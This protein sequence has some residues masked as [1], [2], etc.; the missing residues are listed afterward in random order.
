MARGRVGAADGER[1]DALAEL[2]AWRLA[3]LP[4]ADRRAVESIA[5]EDL[6]DF[7]AVLQAARYLM[8]KYDDRREVRALMKDLVGI[9]E[10]STDGLGAIDDQICELVLSVEDSIRR[11]KDAQARMGVMLPAGGH[12]DS[13]TP[14]PAPASALEP[15]PAPAPAPASALEPAPAPAPVLTAAQ[16][17]GGGGGYPRPRA[18]VAAGGPGRPGA[19]RSGVNNLTSRPAIV[20]TRYYQQAGQVKGGAVV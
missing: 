3:C 5:P 17:I 4:T 12:G 15:A 6:R 9:I 16:R 8:F 19:G 1:M 18:R 7:E 2:A 14:A 20:D 10:R 13:A 11:I